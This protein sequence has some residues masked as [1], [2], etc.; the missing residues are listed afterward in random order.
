MLVWRLHSDDNDHADCSLHVTHTGGYSIH[1]RWGGDL[2]FTALAVDLRT[3]RQVID[4]RREALL[5]Q[6]WK[7]HTRNPEAQHMEQRMLLQ[8]HILLLDLDLQR[9]EQ[10]ARVLRGRGF[11]ISVMSHIAEIERWPIGQ[12]VVVDAARFTPWWAE[13]GAARVVVLSGTSGEKTQVYNGVPCMWIPHGSD[14]DA[15]IAAL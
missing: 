10:L 12:I 9:R 5:R 7:P 1:V 6:G 15:L 4:D 2:K 11:T 13:V 3:A 8:P 14:P